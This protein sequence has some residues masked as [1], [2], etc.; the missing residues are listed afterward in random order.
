MQPVSASAKVWM[1][2]CCSVILAVGLV[3]LVIEITRSGDQILFT[4][5]FVAIVAVMLYRFMTLKVR[6]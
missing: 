5:G 4:L 6:K 3:R 2:S 1:I